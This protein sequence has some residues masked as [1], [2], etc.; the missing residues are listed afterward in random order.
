VSHDVVIRQLLEEGFSE[1]EIWIV[2]YTRTDED[3][4]EFLESDLNLYEH[5]EIERFRREFN[6]DEHPVYLSV[7]ID[8]LKKDI[9]PGTGYPDGKLELEA[10]ENLIKSL[11]FNHADLVEVAP[12]LD[13]GETVESARKIL[14]TIERS[15]AAV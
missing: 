7:D 4:K 1:D 12:T 10:V 2:G 13:D 6:S 5:D 11:Q 9:V 8:V 15:L 3:E 14:E